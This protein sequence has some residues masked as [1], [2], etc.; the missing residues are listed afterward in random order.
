M[1]RQYTTKKAMRR[2]DAS[3]KTASKEHAVSDAARTFMESV[4]KFS[5]QHGAKHGL[6]NFTFWTGAGFSKSWDPKAPIGCDLFALD[7]RV[8]EQVAETSVLQQMLG[9]KSFDN[10][11]P[12]ELRQIVYYRDMYARYPDVRSRY[13]DEQNLQLLADALR[14]AVVDRYNQIT[15]LNFFDEAA[16]KFVVSEPTS[17]QKSII[18]FFYHLSRRIDGSLGF[19]QGIGLH[20]VT[21]NYD[22]V[23][24]TIL[25]NIVGCEESL[26]LYTYRGF[27]PAVVV[28][29]PN[30]MPIHTR[31]APVNHLLKING[32][33]E[34]LRR[35]D[36]YLLDYSRRD[37][38]IILRDPPVLMLPS[39]EQDYSDAYFQTIFPKSVRL[40]RE[41]TVLVLV[42]YS[43]PED[44]ALI[45]F[46]LRQFAEEADDARW[47]LV[48]YIGPDSREEKRLR[49]AEIFPS[50]KLAGVP[51][52]VAYE[53]RFEEFVTECL[54]LIPD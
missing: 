13:V 46:I 15:R 29:R 44:D 45:R 32:G 17:P 14:A 35:G 9:L 52:I 28:N 2:G 43:L 1:M 23:I 22:Y 42:G 54:T 49:L 25:D 5:Y 47:K 24:E 39:R 27:T 37:P 34:I 48:F 30:I 7:P 31:W 51:K 19:G 4:E 3:K 10:I 33:F 18:K 41:T 6:T 16:Q 36:K 26:F 21:T 38:D 53:G 12:D 50:I 8:V 11:S 20:F 40:L